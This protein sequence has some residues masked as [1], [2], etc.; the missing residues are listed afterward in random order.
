MQGEISETWIKPQE[1]RQNGRLDFKAL[2]A[3]YG[4]EG[5]KLVQIKEAEVLRKTLHYKDERAMLFKKFLTN[6]QSMFTGFA[7]NEEVLTDQQKIR[8]LFEKVQS[9]VSTQVK[10][11]LQV[12][13]NLD[14]TSDVTFDFIANSLAAEVASLP[15]YAQ[16]RQ[17]SKIDS[18]RRTGDAPTQGIKL[19]NGAKITGYYKNFHSMP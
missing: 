17:A 6:M 12:S 13:Y 10:A 11:S 18:S 16:T 4:G 1:R 2:Q 15:E 7:D 14:Q 9:L 8:L 3:H 5:N 19:S